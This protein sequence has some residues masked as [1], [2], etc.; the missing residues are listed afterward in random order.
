M[1]SIIQK[2]LTNNPIYINENACIQLEEIDQYDLSLFQLIISNTEIKT[3]GT[4]C[5]L[6]ND[7]PNKKDITDIQQFLLANSIVDSHVS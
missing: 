6:I 4:P 1:S 7:F 2:Q 5:M 3:D